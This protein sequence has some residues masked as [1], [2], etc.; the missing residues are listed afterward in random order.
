MMIEIDRTLSL[1]KITDILNQ[2]L[3]RQ[4]I[5]DYHATTKFFDV[6]IFKYGNVICSTHK[7]KN[8]RLFICINLKNEN[9]KGRIVS[10]NFQPSP[11][12]RFYY[13]K[14]QVTSL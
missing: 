4:K 3:K 14:H 10:L 12:K 13:I 2:F 6:I 9:V 7:K 8:F 1:S 5:F 11:K